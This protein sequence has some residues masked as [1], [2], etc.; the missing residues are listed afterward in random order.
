MEKDK[1]EKLIEFLIKYKDQLDEDLI[2]F[3]EEKMESF[4]EGDC[5][6]DLLA[7]I[8]YAI[9]AKPKKGSVYDDYFEFLKSNFGLEQ[10][11]LEVGCGYYPA[12]ASM[13]DDYQKEKRSGSIEAYDPHLLVTKQG[14][15]KLHRCMFETLQNDKITLITS[16]FPCEGSLTI[17]DEA[18]KNNIDYSILMCECV[19]E[20]ESYYMPFYMSSDMWLNRVYRYAKDSV[21]SDRTIEVDHIEHADTPIIYSKRKR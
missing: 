20:S 1:E 2:R 10:D 7:Q 14:N 17:I 16:I 21:T 4:I 13:I 3:V 12:F 6:I 11:I 18:S 19:P 5:Q 9:E 15:I 8:A